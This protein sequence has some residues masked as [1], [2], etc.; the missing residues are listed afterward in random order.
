MASTLKL[1][2]QISHVLSA[3]GPETF[4]RELDEMVSRRPL[5]EESE[6]MQ[7][8]TMV[9]K[10]YPETTAHKLSAKGVDFNS[11]FGRSSKAVE[12]RNIFIFLI[13]ELSESAFFILKKRYD[14]K[15]IKRAILFSE[16]LLP[17]NP[18]HQE[19]L[20][21]IENIKKEFQLKSAQ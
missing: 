2:Q 15:R 10:Y 4:S 3:I 9:A 12:A 7:I 21:I 19:I 6:I 20:L 5:Q 14:S 8:A 13:K 11:G 16:G 17:K 1:F 18:V